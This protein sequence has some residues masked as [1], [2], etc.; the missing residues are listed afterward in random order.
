[1]ARINWEQV[2]KAAQSVATLPGNIKPLN[3]YSFF[4]PQGEIVAADMYPPLHHPRAVDFF[5]FICLHNYGFWHGDH[6]GYVG[7][8]VGTLDGKE[9]KGSDL[10]WRIAMRQFNR[11][12]DWFLVERLADVGADQMKNELFVDDNGIIPF[13]DLQDRIKITREYGY[14]LALRGMTPTLIIKNANDEKNT[15]ATFLLLMRSVSGYDR[16]LFEKRQLLLAMVLHNRPEGFLRVTD[17]DRWR[18]IV[19]YHL[20]R[21]CL[22]SG[23]VMLDDQELGTNVD[24]AWVDEEAEAEIRRQ[25]YSALSRIQSESGRSHALNDFAFW[26]ARKS[27]PE[28]KNPDCGKCHFHGFC[29]KRTEFFQPVLRTTHY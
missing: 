19:D 5:F 25:C 24:R 2:K 28:M 1:M 29:A 3:F 9:R 14:S 17:P 18:P 13:P 20:M 10:L 26:K 4:T 12:P 11:D 27:C 8:L 16:D 22:R 23:V 7:P 6:Q 15:L 21:V